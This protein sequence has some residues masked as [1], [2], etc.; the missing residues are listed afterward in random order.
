MLCFRS[1]LRSKDEEDRLALYRLLEVDKAA[2]TDV[3]KKAYKKKSLQLHPDKLAQRGMEVT[4][5]HK[6]S[7][8]RLKEA[9]DILTDPK[10]RKLYDQL[11]ES[12]LQLMENPNPVTLIK[13]FQQH[14]ADQ[15]W[16]ILLLS[17]FFGCL[18]ILPILFVLKC[19]GTLGPASPWVSI[20]TPMW[21]VDLAL[22]ILAVLLFAQKDEPSH[23]EDEHGNP[24]VDDTESVPLGLKIVNF[25]SVCAFVVAQIFVT[26]RLDT[27]ITWDWFAVF[28]PWFLFEAIIVVMAG[29][30]AFSF[31]PPPDYASL[32]PAGARR[33]GADGEAGEDGD[34]TEEEYKMKRAALGAEYYGELFERAQARNEVLSHLLRIWQVRPSA[35]P[36]RITPRGLC[37]SFYAVGLRR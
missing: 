11:G 6:Q 16:I 33:A 15:C 26:A 28:A 14:K 21:V 23:S 8:L 20:W 24:V 37:P 2:P 32:P 25:V 4:P 18:F 3:I 5:E 19:D 1:C 34:D 22:L 9:H 17:F 30:T 31:V 27:F 29:I 36:C 12:G 10:R 13:N 35:R 7:F